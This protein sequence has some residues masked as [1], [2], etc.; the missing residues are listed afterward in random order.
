[1]TQDK[2]RIND[3]DATR[4]A[5]RPTHASHATE[6]I[7]DAHTDDKTQLA[8]PRSAVAANV[9]QPLT[10]IV[11]N[12]QT[13]IPNAQTNTQQAHTLQTL[14]VIKGRFELI[15]RIGAGGMGEVF[16]ARDRVRAEMDDNQ[17]YLAI[18]VLKGD[19][20]LLKHAA[21]ALQREAK[22]AQLLSHPNIVTV[23]DFDRDK[24]TAFI[25]MELLEGQS[26]ED[27]LIHSPQ[28]SPTKAIEV[29]KA[30]AQGLAYAHQKGYVH[31]DIKPANI[32]LTNDGGVKILDFGI[33]QAVR[34]A[35][36][37]NPAHVLSEGEAWVKNALTPSYASPQMFSQTDLV[38]SDDIYGLGVVFYELLTGHHPFRDNQTKTISADIA[39]QQKLRIGTVKGLSKRHNIAL[40]KA[41]AFDANKRFANASEFI[42][43]LNPPSKLRLAFGLSLLTALVAIGAIIAMETYE[44]PPPTLADLPEALASTRALITEA[45]ALLETGEIGMA[46]RLYA[47]GKDTLE[48]NESIN[49]RTRDA[50]FYILRERQS[51]VIE[52][53]IVKSESQTLSLFELKEIKLALEYLATDPLTDNKKRVVKQLEKITQRL[54]NEDSQ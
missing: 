1:M 25:T 37:D 39:Q 14:K 21:Q 2:T 6:L 28:M 10:D 27:F 18:K 5:S 31:A 4:I 48:K 32:F 19:F 13:Q 24:D 33:A 38:P 50:A 26:L 36:D 8:P 44:P 29:I 23:Y 43:A 9:T 34:D 54:S 22:K 51:R 15:K 3:S 47:Q 16:L 41:L 35:N 30:A 12:N 17:P 42:K 7:P 52:Q 46:Y 11:D 40:Q 20:S 45:D 53:L 49:S